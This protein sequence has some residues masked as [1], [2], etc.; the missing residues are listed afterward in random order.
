M[1]KTYKTA[2]GK[3]VDFETL[4]ARNENTIAV[5][6]VLMNARGDEIDAHGNVVRSLE[7]RA[8][9]SYNVH[10]TVPQE[11]K[12]SLTRTPASKKIVADPVATVAALETT[13]TVPA[14]THEEIEQ[15]VAV[16]DIAQAAEEVVPADAVV[17]QPSSERKKRSGGLAAATAKTAT[18]KTPPKVLP[19][20]EQKRAGAGVKRV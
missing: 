17:E 18:S 16:E 2:M 7:D 12:Q 1:G 11:S 9:A 3:T 8:R 19:A 20:R 14:A 15:A 4:I 13:A 6:N 10:S 5:G